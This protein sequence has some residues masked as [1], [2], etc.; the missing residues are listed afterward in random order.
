[1]VKQYTSVNDN[2]ILKLKLIL[3]RKHLT[4][5]VNTI[6]LRGMLCHEK[7]DGRHYVKLM[8]T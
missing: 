8:T 2:T 3:I 1:M 4:M 5:H 7:S 6:L